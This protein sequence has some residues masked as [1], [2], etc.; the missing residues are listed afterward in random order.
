MMFQTNLYRVN[1]KAFLNSER[2]D[3]RGKTFYPQMSQMY[4]DVK[5]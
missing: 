2:H 1:C 5:I 3:T 4:A